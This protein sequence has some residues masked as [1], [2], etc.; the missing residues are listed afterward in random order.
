MD[1]ELRIID[2][3]VLF[4]TISGYL[5]VMPVLEYIEILENVNISL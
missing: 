5:V 2:D 1:I 3:V 4:E